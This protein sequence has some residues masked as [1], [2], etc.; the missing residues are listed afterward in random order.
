MNQ[1][2]TA[3]LKTPLGEAYPA[4]EKL[5]QELKSGIPSAFKRLFNLYSPRT[6]N[7]AFRMLQ[8]KQDAEDVTQD[9]FLQVY[10]SL[11]HFRGDA[12][13][14]TWLYRITVN[15]SLNHQRKRKFKRWISINTESSP[16]IINENDDESFDIAGAP[17]ENPAYEMERKETE[18]IVQE[19]I[20]SLP[21]Q[22]RV[23]VLLYRYEGLS[24]EEIAKIMDVSVASVESRLHRAK[25][26][27]TKRLLK[28][29]K[30]L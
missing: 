7:V 24:Y 5:L 11:K 28:I 13:I 16:S 3:S 17:E 6:F 15:L 29:K 14:S 22:Q 12:K 2:I 23:A 1:N 26:A 21:E 27:L 4:G 20:K 10:K 30:E 9:V 19:A 8:N 18:Q 25:I